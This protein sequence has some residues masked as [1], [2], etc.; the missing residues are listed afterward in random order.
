MVLVAP[1]V[2]LETDLACVVQHGFHAIFFTTN[3]RNT[4][5]PAHARA[6]GSGVFFRRRVWPFF[7]TGGRSGHADGAQDR[8][9]G[10]REDAPPEQ[11]VSAGASSAA[12]VPPHVV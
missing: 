1:L 8:E 5:R 10:D 6:A 4:P 2:L 7:C 11:E 9:G 12:A 3:I